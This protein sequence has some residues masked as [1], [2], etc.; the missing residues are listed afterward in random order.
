MGLKMAFFDFPNGGQIEV[1]APTGPDSVLRPALVS[2]QS[3]PHKQ[4]DF[5][6]RERRI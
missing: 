1:V 6:W 4:L 2:P 5:P 3:N